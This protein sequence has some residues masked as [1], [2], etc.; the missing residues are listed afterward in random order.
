MATNNPVIKAIRWL[1]GNKFALTSDADAKN[2]PGGALF[3]TGVETGG[4]NIRAIGK[5]MN[6]SPSIEPVYGNEFVYA[7]DPA[8]TQNK[9]FRLYVDITAVTVGANLEYELSAST[10]TGINLY[11][12]SRTFNL[13]NIAQVLNFL[14]T[15]LSGFTLS[16]VITQTTTSSTTGYLDIEFTDAPGYNYIFTAEVE[17]GLMELDVVITQ[18]SV[19]PS[20]TGEW[21]LIGSNDRIGD[22]FQFWTTRI[23]LTEEIRIVD[24]TNPAST[25]IQIETDGDHNLVDGQS[26]RISEVDGVTEANGEWLITNLTATTFDLVLASFSGAYVSGGIVTSNIYG[27][28]EIGVA[29]QDNNGVTSYTRLLRSN[30]LNFSTLKQ[31]DARSKRKQDSLM[32]VPF[33]DNFNPPRQFYYKGAYITDGAVTSV[34]ADGQYSYGSIDVDIRLFIAAAGFGIKWINQIQTGGAVKSGNWR[35]SIRF[36]TS[37]LTPTLW[38]QMTDVVPVFIA[39]IYGDPNVLLGDDENIVTPKQNVLEITNSIPGI[40][41]FCEIAAVNYIGGSFTG[42][43]I[44]RYLLDGNTIQYINHTGNENA[45]TD[46]DLGE[47]S[48]VLPAIGLARNLE[49]FDGRVVL[50]N[51]T[52]S[53]VIDFTPWVETFQ[54]SIDRDTANPIGVYNSNNTGLSINEYQLPTNV[55]NYKTHMIYETYRYG[56]KFRMKDTGMITPVYYPGYDIKID[57]PLILP[58]ER[59]AGTFNSFDLTDNVAP[60]TEV[61]T[62]FIN[63]QNIDM[64]FLING[65][66]AYQLVDQIIP[67]RVEVSNPTTLGHGVAIPGMTGENLGAAFSV[68]EYNDVFGITG[69]IGPF[70]Y[71]SGFTNLDIAC[72]GM[73]PINNPTYD[74]QTI[75]TPY[76]DPQR[77]SAFFYFPDYSFGQTTILFQQGDQLISFGSPERHSEYSIQPNGNDID[78]NYAEFNG[79]TNTTANPTPYVINDAIAAGFGQKLITVDGK[80]HSLTYFLAGLVQGNPM[81]VEQCI[82][83]G[84]ASDLINSGPNTD[85]GFYRSIYYRPLANQYGDPNTSIYEE[86]RTPHNIGNETGIIAP[87]SLTSYG[88][89]FNQ[90]TYLKFRNPLHAPSVSGGFGYGVGYYSQNR[91]N[92][93]LRRK[94]TPTYNSGVMIPNLSL[95]NWLYIS[96]NDTSTSLSEMYLDHRDVQF[97]YNAGY[98][99]RNDITSDR[100]FDSNLTYQ[101]DWGNFLAWSEQDVPGSNTDYNR[102]FLPLNLKALDYAFGPITD[103]RDVNGLLVTLQYSRLMRQYFNTTELSVTELGSE[104]ILGDGGVMRREGVVLTKFGSQHK[105]SVIVAKSD[106]GNDVLLFVDA[107]NKTVCRYGYNGNDAIDEIDGMKSFFANNLQWIQGKDTP[108]HDEGIH[109]VPSQRYR[110][111][112]WT[113]RGWIE[114]IGEWEDEDYPMGAVVMV[115]AGVNSF[116]QIPDFYVA[117]IDSPSGPPAIDNPDWITIEKT[118]PQYYSFFTLTYDLLRSRWQSFLTPKPKIYARFRNTFL[119]PRPVSDTGRVY[120]SDSDTPTRWFQGLAPAQQGDAFFDAVINYPAGRKRF[121]AVRVEADAA[122]D[123]M[124]VFTQG[125]ETFSPNGLFV[126]RPVG[127]WDTSVRN[128]SIVTGNADG[129]TS[130]MYGD[131]AIFRFI[132][133]ATNYNKINNFVAKVRSLAREFQK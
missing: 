7:L 96:Y 115:S 91:A 57:L 118:N 122:P 87:G 88:D 18:E 5:S 116:E 4:M 70:A 69:K 77:D 66:P 73:T 114:G 120:I 43:V 90:K 119:V 36:L 126:E 101:T 131:Y 107:I 113:F 59:I 37:T 6:V 33:T 74:Q 26:V 95:E 133:S 105:W 63:W 80:D 1:F 29:V 15:D 16:P 60:P 53:N 35:Y 130:S 45:V 9:L 47:L 111:V 78:I 108:A 31:I 10:P 106:K 84:L 67:C 102:I 121:E 125:Q 72:A 44:G 28:G 128:N 82:V 92:I 20:M 81:E 71:F 68:G 23:G 123:M 8:V 19:D 32:A 85:Y 75:G 30:E 98:T 79:Y 124:R 127:E 40:F 54:Y 48:A 76:E 39:N 12:A 99:P 103:T 94:P 61:Y 11:T 64:G 51:L 112:I 42:F 89:C 65:I 86:F 14:D 129:D 104:V 55:Y 41:K 27:L 110:E 2:M 52:P 3:V 21:N 93:Q 97:F 109:A 24:V 56:F 13:I 58:P 132:I 83:C 50:S 38:S 117:R 22:C 17:D 62:I 49:V 25:T 34:S 100:A 46:L